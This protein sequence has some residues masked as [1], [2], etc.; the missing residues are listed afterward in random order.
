[1]RILE[2]ENIITEINNPIWGFT[3][4]DILKRELVNRKVDQKKIPRPKHKGKIIIE[5]ILKRMYMRHIRYIE[6]V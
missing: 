1:M 4:I 3:I 6:M 2:L 5:K